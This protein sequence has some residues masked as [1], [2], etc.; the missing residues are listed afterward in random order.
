MTLVGEHGIGCGGCRDKPFAERLLERAPA[1]RVDERLDLDADGVLAELGR[2][3]CDDGTLSSGVDD[4]DRHGGVQP[5]ASVGRR[6]CCDPE[7]EVPGGRVGSV[8][9]ARRDAVAVAVRVVAEIRAAAHDLGLAPRWS[10][11]IAPGAVDVEVPVGSRMMSCPSSRVSV[12]RSRP[13]LPISFV[14]TPPRERG[15]VLANSCSPTLHWRVLNRRQRRNPGRRWNEW[16][17][18]LRG[19]AWE[20][21]L[22]RAGQSSTVRRRL[23]RRCPGSRCVADPCRT[24]HVQHGASGHRRQRPASVDGDGAAP[25][26]RRRAARS[27]AH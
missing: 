18:P 3:S 11:R 2:R 12:F 9:A 1:C 16:N 25:G 5:G 14:T 20:R 23:L 27:R 13:G 4:D 21:V 22:D 19:S 24:S 10:L 26:L 7:T 17:D 6:C 8:R 15:R